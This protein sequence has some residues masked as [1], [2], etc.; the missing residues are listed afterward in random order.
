MI[1][2]EKSEAQSI[3]TQSQR[4]QHNKGR[5]FNKVSKLCSTRQAKYLTIIPMQL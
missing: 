1:S 3:N 2:H 5:S 4:N